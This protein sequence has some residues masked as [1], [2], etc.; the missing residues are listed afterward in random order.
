MIPLLFPKSVYAKRREMLAKRLVPGQDLV[1]FYNAPEK[2]R[3]YDSHYAYRPDSHFVYMTGYAEA[4][5]A[6]LLWREKAGG[7]TRTRF[8]L[9]VLPRDPAMEQWDGYRYGP[10]GARKLTGAT[11][12][13]EIEKL[14][15]AIL[16]WFAQ[17]P[18]AG[19]AP[20]VFTNAFAESENKAH[21]FGVVEKFH[22]RLRKGRLEIESIHD[23]TQITQAFRRVKDA[24]ELAVMRRSSQINVAAHLKLMHDLRPGMKEFE[25]RGLLES[26]YMR[27][28]ALDVAYGTIAA[29]GGNATIL[30]YRAGNEVCRKNELLLVDAGCELDFYASDITRTLPVGGRYTREQKIIMDLVMDAH[31]AAMSKVRV[32]NRYAEIHEAASEV[33]HKGL[34][35]LKLLPK[36]V[37]YTR[38]YP[39]GTGHWLGLD[40][41]DPCG[42]VDERGQS[43]RLEAG[44]VMTIEPGL[45]FMPNDRKAPR[46]YR[47]IGVR[48]EDDVV[49]TKGGKPEILTAGLPRTADEIEEEMPAR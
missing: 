39:H 7:A 4:H 12:G 18:G 29:A 30:H 25:V 47:G 14:E 19:V 16:Q 31:Q 2:V 23:V 46:E 33:L 8:E 20:R 42:Y 40:V 24:Q 5:S 26:E 28:G 11:G 27:L 17:V 49:V 45:Y 41:H 36:G 35:R 10:A 13:Y 1:V 34:R 44:M 21:F 3:N 9:F 48:I 38:F 37:E 43:L 15:T 22:P 32:G 6:F